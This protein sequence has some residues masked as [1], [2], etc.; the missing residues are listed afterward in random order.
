MTSKLTLGSLFDGSGGFP[1][2]GALLGIKPVWASEIE[3][4]PLKVTAARFPD[5]IQLG[6]ITKINGTAIPA[7]D[8]ITFGSPCQDLSVAGRRA[9]LQEGSR[10][11]LFFE[12][13]RVIKE[14][15]EAT[16]GK[17]PRFLV[18]ENVKGALS[19]AKGADF[20]VALEYLCRVKDPSASIPQPEKKWGNAGAIVGDGYSLAWRIYDAQYWG[21]P[22][23]RERLF[24]VVDLGGE[25]AG[26]VFFKP[27]SVSGYS[28][29]GRKA[30]KGIAGHSEEDLVPDYVLLEHHPPDC[31]IKIAAGD[32]CQTLSE[33][34]GTGGGA[35]CR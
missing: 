15:R 9:G 21:V 13:V 1:L 30:W 26:E 3:P 28:E 17:S 5:M 7:V 33:R 29:Q 24:L 27:E 6:D 10:S 34:M 31:R 23:H 20:R 12:A 19:S 11:S 8:I 14:M 32:V 16:N 35:M 2:A 25:R 22:Q 18:W 4:Y